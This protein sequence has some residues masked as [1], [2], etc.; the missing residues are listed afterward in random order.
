MLGAANSD[1]VI[2]IS[3]IYDDSGIILLIFDKPYFG[4]ACHPTSESQS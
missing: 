3:D 2:T 1:W 4:K